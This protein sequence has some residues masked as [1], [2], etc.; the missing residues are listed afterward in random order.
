MMTHAAP[1]MPANAQLTVGENG[2]VPQPERPNQLPVRVPVVADCGGSLLRAE[3]L[4]STNNVLLL[5]G[6]DLGVALPALGTPVRLKVDWDQQVLTGRLAAHGVA[7][8]FLVT[9]GER[10][11]RRSRRFP[12]N[13]NGTANCAHLYG[14]VDVR[15]V[16]LST[17]G[18][19]IE[20]IDLP[21]GTELELR[22][23]PPGKSAPITVLAF[24]VRSIGKPDVLTLGVAFRLVQPSIDSLTR[25]AA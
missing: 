2:L 5:Q 4:G 10:A 13:L 16:D 11:I 1:S 3:V 14:P 18:A 7:S 21:V 23:T 12:V 15:V 24:V 19:R 6:T 9:L 8:R 25:Q 22:F 17:G 20:G